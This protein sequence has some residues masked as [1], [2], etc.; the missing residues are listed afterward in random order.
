M[1]IK[2]LFHSQVP[3]CRVGGVRLRLDGGNIIVWKERLL[4]QHICAVRLIIFLAVKYCFK[5]TFNQR[6]YVT[7]KLT[8]FLLNIGYCITL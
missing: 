3:N 4:I 8:Y 5:A 7:C 1:F 2:E 6:K